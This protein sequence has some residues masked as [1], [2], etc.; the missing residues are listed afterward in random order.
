VAEG[1]AQTRQLKAKARAEQ[2][3]RIRH[4]LSQGEKQAD[5]ARALGIHTSVVNRV[6]RGK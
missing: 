3:A 1:F 6:K 2:E 4:L 5:V